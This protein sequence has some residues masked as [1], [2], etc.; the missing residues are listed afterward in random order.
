MAAGFIG[1][2]AAA[3]NAK[4]T[5]R[6]PAAKRA[7]KLS[8]WELYQQQLLKTSA[9]GDEYFGHLK[10]SYLGINNTFH[11]EAVRAGAYTTN[12][13]IISQVDYA[14][15]AMHA[16]YAKYPHDPQL[17]R[18]WFLAMEMYRKIYT[19][20]AQQKAWEYMHEIAQR[21]PNTYFG[22]LMVKDLQIGFTEHYFATPQPCPSPLPT[23]S[24]AARPT[25]APSPS[26]SPSPNPEPTVAPTS[27]P[28]QPAVVVLPVPCF[29]PAPTPTPSPVSLPSAAPATMPQPLPSGKLTPVPSPAPLR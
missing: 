18:S 21:W 12:P 17:A 6:K 27:G 11:D 13:G 23:G 28:N 24:P 3:P 2:A 29:T 22:K 15:D 14:D 25:L 8:K 5:V 4:S 16:W 7:P 9:P 1:S 20:P 26:P 19:Q 10:L